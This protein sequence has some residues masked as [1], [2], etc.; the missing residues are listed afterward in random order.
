M[1]NNSSIRDVEFD[2]TDNIAR[3][4]EQRLVSAIEYLAK[5]SPWYR[6]MFNDNGIDPSS[7]KSISD[8]TRIPFTTKS[9]LQKHNNEFICVPLNKVIDYVTTSGTLGDPVTFCCT[10]NDL[11][12]LAYNEKNLFLRLVLSQEISCS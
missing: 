9:D 5:K 7:I 10:E 6:K 8:L 4:Q 11:Q 3:F 12:R 2:T 1:N